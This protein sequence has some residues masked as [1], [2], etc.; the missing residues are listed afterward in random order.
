[1][2]SLFGWSMTSWAGPCSSIT[3]PS[4]KMTVSETSRAKVIS[5]VTMI[6]VVFFSASSRMT[7]RTSPVS[8]GSRA[9][10]GSSKQRI[11]G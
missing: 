6:M 1:M 5:W 8:S 2:R 3:P 10:V 4:M 11:S 7:F 9:E